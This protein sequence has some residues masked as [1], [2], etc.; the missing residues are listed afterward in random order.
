[1]P[2]AVIRRTTAAQVA[3]AANVWPGMTAATAAQFTRIGR[4]LPI[5][6]PNQFAQIHVRYYHQQTYAAAG[7]T[8]LTFFQANASEHVT[9]LNNGLTPD[10]RP[11]WLT[12]I[13]CTLQFLTSAGA[14][15]TVQPFSADTVA[16]V[17]F[18]QMSNAMAAGLLQLYVGDRLV[19]EGQGLDK[20]CADGGSWTAPSSALAANNVVPYNNG[21][22]VAGNRFKFPAPYPILPGKPV[23][24]LAKWQAAY[25]ITGATACRLRV[26]LVGESVM[27]LNA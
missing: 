22:P 6:K 14:A 20:Y 27:P 1:M 15:S 9:N 11:F 18:Q 17:A 23:K 25:A 4:G 8:Q 13:T 21:L 7:Q 5:S 16:S 10:E 26:E 2:A 12:G 19:H 24:V 3:Q